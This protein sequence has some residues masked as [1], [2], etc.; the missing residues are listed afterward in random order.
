MTV[1]R[2]VRTGGAGRLVQSPPCI[3][4]IIPSN[5]KRGDRFGL[6]VVGYGQVGVG[7]RGQGHRV[8]EGDT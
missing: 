4:V 7:G 6:D 1:A 3:E 5:H 2:V 8:A